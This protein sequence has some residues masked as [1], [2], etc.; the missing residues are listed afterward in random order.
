MFC[1][2]CGAQVLP[3]MQFCSSCGAPVDAVQ[4]EMPQ[5]AWIAPGFSDRINDPAFAAYIRRS[6]KISV[7]FGIAMAIIALVGFVI[8][9]VT[10]E[11]LLFGLLLGTLIGGMFLVVTLVSIVRSR[12]GSTWDG[13]VVD[14]KVKKR[15]RK[16]G[17]SGR[18][19]RYNEYIVYVK[20]DDGNT[21]KVASTNT[22]A[23]FDYYRVGDRV[24]RHPGLQFY[25]KYDKS[26]DAEILCNACLQFNPVHADVCSRCKC[27]VL[28]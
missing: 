13:T 8:Y 19:S 2:D 14:K 12:S 17:S 22:S 23:A 26:G 11:N 28:K 5:T 4:P 6:R 27:P 9:G 10:Q 21:H 25:E 15:T 7:I 16:Q 1:S 18:Q 3:G 24:R 20:S